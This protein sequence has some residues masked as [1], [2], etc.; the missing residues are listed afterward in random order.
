MTLYKTRS[1]T[2][3][4]MIHAVWTLA[5]LTWAIAGYQYGLKEGYDTG[6]AAA[7]REHTE[8]HDKMREMNILLWCDAWRDR[9]I[10]RQEKSDE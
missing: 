10:K 4:W 3:M 8:L 9:H 6:E 5:C 1:K 2:T 7:D